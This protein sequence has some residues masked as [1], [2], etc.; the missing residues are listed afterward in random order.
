VDGQ[1]VVDQVGREES[2]EVVRAGF[3]CSFPLAS[4]AR[5]LWSTT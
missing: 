2:T 3:L 5:S 1:A 4:T